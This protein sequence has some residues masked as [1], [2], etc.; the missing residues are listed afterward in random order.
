MV[1]E[2]GGDLTDDFLLEIQDGTEAHKT[3]FKVS[4]DIGHESQIE[5]A[6]A[7]YVKDYDIQKH[8]M[9]FRVKSKEPE[10]LREAV[11]KFMKEFLEMA[12]EHMDS[13]E[14]EEVK[15]FEMETY[16]VEGSVVF[17]MRFGDYGVCEE[18]ITPM[19]KIS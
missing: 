12:E 15:H 18:F 8:Y 3:E 6:V 17:K 2:S 10:K 1:S 14:F 19:E 7:K 9:I 16:V 4:F 11:E 5:A 13:R